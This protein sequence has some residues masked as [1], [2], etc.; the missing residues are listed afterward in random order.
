MVVQN[1]DTD[2]DLANSAQGTV[3]GLVLHTDEPS[4]NEDQA[5]V[6]L[7]Y[8]PLYILVKLDR[9]CVMKLEG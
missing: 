8:L 6:E 7:K 5:A 1:T 3:V 4:I 2:L 9:T